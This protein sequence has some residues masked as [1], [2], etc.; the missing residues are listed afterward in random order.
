MLSSSRNQVECAFGYLKARSTILK[1]K[2]N[3]K[4]E[5]LPTIF[6]GCFVCTI[7]VT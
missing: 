5:M 1:I 3:L 7:T 6:Y 2:I 4:F